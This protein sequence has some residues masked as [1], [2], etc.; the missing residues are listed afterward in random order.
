M[1]RHEAGREPRQLGTVSPVPGSCTEHE[2]S[3]IARA[4]DE[5]AKAAGDEVVAEG[6]TGQEFYLILDGTASVTRGAPS[7]ASLGPGQYFGELSLLGRGAAE[8]HGHRHLG[9]VTL[10]AGPPGSRPCSTAGPAWPGSC[11]PSWPGGC[12]RPTSWL[13]PTDVVVE[14]AEI[15]GCVT[16]VV[17]SDGRR[18]L[19]D[20]GGASRRLEVWVAAASHGTGP[21]NG[22]LWRSRLPQT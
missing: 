5:V 20:R 2:L 12:G 21:S 15:A 8:R 16:E 19:D 9:A 1:S 17:G 13:S 10:D 11:S 6:S 4:G 22:P 3:Q 14:S 7:L 18:R